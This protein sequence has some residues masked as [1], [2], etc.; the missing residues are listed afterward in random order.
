MIK[1]IVFKFWYP[2]YIHFT[3]PT[4]K[5]KNDLSMPSLSRKSHLAAAGRSSVQKQTMAP[6][7]KG[8]TDSP[9]TPNNFE[10][11][12]SIGDFKK[13]IRRRDTLKAFKTGKVRGSGNMMYDSALERF[14]RQFPRKFGH[15]MAGGEK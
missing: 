14:S 2:H 4:Q 3:L 13:T 10:Y 11:L 7:R 6:R 5:F 1:L 8:A 12:K 15:R 9:R